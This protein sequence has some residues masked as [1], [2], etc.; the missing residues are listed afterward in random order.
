VRQYNGALMH[1]AKAG[2]KLG[3]I[4]GQ[5]SSVRLTYFHANCL[6]TGLYKKETEIS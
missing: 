4:G 5:N 6:L 2:T 1:P 3:T